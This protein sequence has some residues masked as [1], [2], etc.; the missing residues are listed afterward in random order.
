[1]S[2]LSGADGAGMGAQIGG[3][4]GRIGGRDGR[5]NE[6]SPMAERKAVDITGS[7]GRS[8]SMSSNT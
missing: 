1:M 6:D 4:G 3:R 8:S 5:Q 2:V 7:H